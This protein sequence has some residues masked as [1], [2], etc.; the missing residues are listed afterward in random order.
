MEVREN[1]QN[2]PE[3]QVKLLF[4]IAIYFPDRYFHCPRRLEYDIGC[5]TKRAANGAIWL[6]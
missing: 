3:P 6:F 4:I 1:K 2:K 5:I